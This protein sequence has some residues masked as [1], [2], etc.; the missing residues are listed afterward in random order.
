MKDFTCSL[1]D[2]NVRLGTDD[3]VAEEANCLGLKSRLVLSTPPQ[4]AEV[5]RSGDTTAFNATA[6]GARLDP[7]R[8]VVGQDLREGLAQLARDLGAPT[9]L[10]SLGMPEDGIARATDQA[11]E[12]PCWNP[13]KLKRDD[14][15]DLIHQAW[16]CAP[17]QEK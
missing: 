15:H 13:R 16:S 10:R 5:R 8:S 6:V 7:L 4:E 2:Q 3:V 9:S 1:Q 12:A 17:P 11:M 14:T